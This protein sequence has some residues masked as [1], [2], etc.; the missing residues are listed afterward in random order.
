MHSAASLAAAYSS[1]DFRRSGTNQGRCVAMPN[2]VHF[3]MIVL[4][5]AS[6]AATARE[7]APIT[8]VLQD[9]GPSTSNHGAR[10]D[11]WMAAGFAVPPLVKVHPTFVDIHSARVENNL[12]LFQPTL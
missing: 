8:L 4:L 5:G 2:R 11:L 12:L 1:A 6:T 3:T 10:V 7:Q 9:R